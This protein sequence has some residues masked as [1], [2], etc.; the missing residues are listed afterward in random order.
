[1]RLPNPFRITRDESPVACVLN[2][3][4]CHELSIGFEFHEPEAPGTPGVAIADELCRVYF[5]ILREKV[6]DAVLAGTEGQV[7][8]VKF[9][10]HVAPS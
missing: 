6:S 5:T 10:S 2:P 4:S 8:H 1:M 3:V 7:A 9:G